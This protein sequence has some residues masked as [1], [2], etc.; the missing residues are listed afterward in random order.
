MNLRTAG[1]CLL[2]VGAL[3]SFAVAAKRPNIVFIFAD[4][5][6][7]DTFGPY[8]DPIVR[9]PNLDRLANRGVRFTHCYNMGSWTGAVC[10]ASRTMLNTGKTLWRARA[11]DTLLQQ[12]ARKKAAAGRTPPKM[13]S[14]RMRGL[15]YETYFTGKWHVK[16]KA[17]KLFDHV[18]HVRPGMPADTGRPPY[19]KEGYS[20]PVKGQ[21]DKWSPYDKSFGGFWE[22]GRHWSAVLADDAVGFLQHA[23]K[24]AEAPQAKPFFMYLAF[25]APHD[26][27]QSPKSF[28][29]SYPLEKI[30]TPAPFFA[31]HPQNT[32]G[33]NPTLRDEALAPYPRTEYAV[34][35]NRR[36]YYAL[37][38]HLDQQIGR[39]LDELRSH[40]FAENTWIFFTADHGLACGHHGLMG[41]QNMYDHSVRP[42]FV[43]VGPGAAPNTQIAQPI[44]LQDVMATCLAIAGDDQRQGIEFQSLLPLLQGT[45][46]RL[47]NVY[48]AYLNTQRMIRQ[49][50]WKLILYPALK[51]K[52]LFNLNDDPLEEHNLADNPAQMAKMRTLF[53]EL[54]ALQKQH[55]DAVALPAAFPK[56]AKS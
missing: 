56:L 3:A 20:R 7:Y 28:V 23:A 53:Q 38:T 12:I 11:A 1:L 27:R 15:G 29:D 25:N 41:K 9:T 5:M 54:Q 19:K 44:Y 49:D 36:E 8:D 34:R 55:A 40:A 16:A 6:S 4:D 10:V 42:P 33:L 47:T 2:L 32:S 26:P 22:G 13:W 50:G 17:E 35:V 48:G 18:V 14:E 39:I 37:I 43:M 45:P 52:L 51:V 30:K 31:K 24:R 46:S 21:P